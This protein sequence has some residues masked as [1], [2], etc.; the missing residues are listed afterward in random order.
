MSTKVAEKN[1]LENGLPVRN[2]GVFGQA[3]C[4]HRSGALT[5]HLPVLRAQVV[6]CGQS[7]KYAWLLSARCHGDS[8]TSHTESVMFQH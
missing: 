3:S 2:V 7:R 1:C 6:R 5:S 4:P 8:L